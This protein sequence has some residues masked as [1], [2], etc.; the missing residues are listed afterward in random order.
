MSSRRGFT[1][2]E[3]LVAILVLGLLLSAITRL[4]INSLSFLTRRREQIDRIF[5][6]KKYLGEFF[7]KYSSFRPPYSFENLEKSDL[8]FQKKIVKKLEEPRVNIEI[9]AVEIDNKSSLS[10]FKEQILIASCE[11]SWSEG[12]VTH[13]GQERSIKM[14]S[15]ILAPPKMEK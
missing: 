15:F 12:D 9:E 2:V 4:E 7:L 11:G 6:I 8:S 14:I 1:F 3:S 13:M 10:V 5:V